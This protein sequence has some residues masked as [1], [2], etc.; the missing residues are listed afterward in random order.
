MTRWITIDRPGYLGRHRNDRY[1]AYDEQYGA[2]N[3]RLQWVA[4]AASGD[5]TVAVTWYE[6]AYM[7]F[8]STHPEVVEQL[9]REASNVY[10]DAPSNVASGFDYRIQET[11]RTH[12]QDIAIRCCLV[13]LGHWFEGKELIRIRDSD[14]THPLSL[15]LSPGRVPFHRPQWI[16]QPELA[17]WCQPGSVE[18]FYQSNKCLQIREN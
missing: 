3:W 1:A 17:G 5:V 10:D 9:A 15:T 14:G 7:A 18:S 12:L 11:G 6:D 13:R 16:M 2:S 4:A 8:L